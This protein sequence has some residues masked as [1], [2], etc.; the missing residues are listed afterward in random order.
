MENKDN[1]RQKLAKVIIEYQN[2]YVKLEKNIL[3]TICDDFLEQLGD[4]L[5]EYDNMSEEEKKKLDEIDEAAGILDEHIEKMDK[6]LKYYVYK[7]PERKA[8]KMRE[9][10]KIIF[11]DDTN[12]INGSDNTNRKN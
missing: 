5:N 10:N 8:R 12:A 2:D 1:L 3:I 4:A 6:I 7:K 9:S 11:Y